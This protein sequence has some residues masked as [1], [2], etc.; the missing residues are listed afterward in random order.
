MQ[1]SSSFS[2]KLNTIHN[3]IQVRDAQ[4]KSID[5][6]GSVILKLFTI[7]HTLLATKSPI[8][9][10]LYLSSHDSFQD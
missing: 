2:C 8:S 7:S 6:N 3:S 9:V 1:S 4:Q 10:D 5:I